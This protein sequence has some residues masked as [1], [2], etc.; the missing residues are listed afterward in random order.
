MAAR[1]SSIASFHALRFASEEAKSVPVLFFFFF[2]SGQTVKDKGP[3]CDHN[4][5]RVKQVAQLVDNKVVSG[6]NL[7]GL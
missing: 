2:F 3:V 6:V 1:Q 7:E 4:I 5:M